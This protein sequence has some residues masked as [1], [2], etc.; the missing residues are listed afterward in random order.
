[1]SHPIVSE[2]KIQQ[3]LNHLFQNAGNLPPWPYVNIHCKWTNLSENALTIN[4]I[5]WYLDQLGKAF[6]RL[7]HNRVNQLQYTKIN[8]FSVTL[9]SVLEP[10]PQLSTWPEYGK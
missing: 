1:M 8:G 4:I 6:W 7:E 9:T 5:T 10:I 3:H 2:I